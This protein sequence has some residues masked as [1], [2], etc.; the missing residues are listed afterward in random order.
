[1]STD[2]CYDVAIVQAGVTMATTTLAGQGP[3]G[4]VG[5]PGADSTVPGP[6]GPQGPSGAQGVQ[7]PAGT[8][9][10]D[11]T[12]PGPQGPTG[13]T[14]P[15]GNTGPQGPQGPQGPPGTGTGDM[16][17]SVYDTNNDN[18][19]DHAALADA[20]PWTGI[21]GKPTTFTPSAHEATHITGGSDIIPVVTASATGLVPV[22]PADV[23]KYLRGD[24]TFARN[25]VSTDVGNLATLGSDN[26]ISVPQS[27][28]WYQRLRSW[29]SVGNSTM[30]LDQRNAGNLISLAAGNVSSM[31]IDRWQ[32]GKNA[33]TATLS[34]TGQFNQTS[35]AQGT[36][37]QISSKMLVVQISTAQTTLAAGE[38]LNIQQSIEGPNLRELLSDVHS[39]QLLCWATVAG[40]YSISLRSANAAYSFVSS[41]ALAASTWTWVTIPNIPVWTASGT[42]STTPGVI[43][44]LFSICLGAGSTF[45][46][47]SGSAVWQAG[48]FLAAPGQTN[49]MATA[50]AQFR[51]AFV[52]HEPGSVCSTP[53]DCPFTGPNGNYDACLRY[54]QKSWDLGTAVATAS[55]VGALALYQQSTTGVCGPCRFFKPMAKIPTATTYNHVTGTANSVRM[56]GGTDYSVSGFNGINTGGFYGLATGTMPA[57]VAGATVLAHYTADTGW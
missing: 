17:K 39:I 21:T 29:N 16:L 4:P 19:V 53:M 6:V 27:S 1:M 13:A 15:Q 31:V 46:A 33:A 11:S 7:G 30:E 49:L 18:I 50:S 35:L 5:P 8:P 56:M 14:G 25:A 41:F 55:A 38:Y 48:N 44:Y 52:Q 43:G 42:W 2:P 32:V 47:P 10:A 45:T 54:F 9:G 36:S 12:V 34:N 37:F 28:L 3:P 57:V 40:N 24:G 20:A 51:C 22:L 23:T 26:L